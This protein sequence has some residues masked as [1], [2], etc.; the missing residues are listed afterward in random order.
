M[1]KGAFATWGP[2]GLGAG[3]RSGS[4]R[5]HCGPTN[6]GLGPQIHTYTLFWGKNESGS[7]LS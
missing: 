1:L 6:I 4:K 3:R 5:A 7:S 2:T